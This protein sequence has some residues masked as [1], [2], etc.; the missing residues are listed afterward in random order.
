MMD[1]SKLEIEKTY[2]KMVEI[3]NEDYLE[4]IKDKSSVIIEDVEIKL[5]KHW[6]IKTYGPPMDYTLERTTA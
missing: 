1:Y 5:Q 2:R 6:S 3:T 4:F